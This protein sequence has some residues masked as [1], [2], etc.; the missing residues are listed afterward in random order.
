MHD[1][2]R[3]PLASGRSREPASGRAKATVGAKDHRI[4]TDAFG[5]R[6]RLVLQRCIGRF[7]F[8]T[9][10]I[11]AISDTSSVDQTGR[12]GW[13]PSQGGHVA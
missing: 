11:A 7:R 12:A 4:F 8:G 3:A 13:A 5:K 1:D 2:R 6:K 10:K 9:D